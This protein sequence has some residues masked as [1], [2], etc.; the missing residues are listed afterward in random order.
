M[1]LNMRVCEMARAWQQ[2]T[3][4][5]VRL[6]GGDDVTEG[7]TRFNMYTKMYTKIAMFFFIRL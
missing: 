3:L 4:Y 2:A 1:C 6:A 5:Y 7:I